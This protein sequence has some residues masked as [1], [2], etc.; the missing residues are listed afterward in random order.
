MSE[1][2]HAGMPVYW[3]AITCIYGYGLQGG[4][5]PPKLNTNFENT[6]TQT[7]TENATRPANRATPAC[8]GGGSGELLSVI[9]KSEAMNPYLDWTLTVLYYVSLPFV[10]LFYCLLFFLRPVWYLL[11]TVLLPFGYVGHYVAKLAAFPLR[12][13]GTLEVCLA[14]SI[15]GD[16]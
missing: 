13:L 15:T 8:G 6:T 7:T 4:A 12:F 9:A 5:L 1:W 11:Y 16:S 10:T 3:R 14:I 2:W